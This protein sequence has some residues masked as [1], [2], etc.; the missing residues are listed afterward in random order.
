MVCAFVVVSVSTAW[1]Q[2][3]TPVTSDNVAVDFDGGTVN[4]V[5]RGDNADGVEQNTA[6]GLKYTALSNSEIQYALFNLNGSFVDPDVR[7][8]ENSTTIFYLNRQYAYNVGNNPANFGYDGCFKPKLV[9]NN[10][11]TGVKTPGIKTSYIT[12]QI[13]YDKEFNNTEVNNPRCCRYYRL[14]SDIRNINIYRLKYS[15]ITSSVGTTTNKEQANL[16]IGG[17]TPD[18]NYGLYKKGEQTALETKQGVASATVFSQLDPDGHDY[19]AT[20]RNVAL[21]NGKNEFEVRDAAGAVVKSITV[22]RTSVASDPT[23]LRTWA[24]EVCQDPDKTAAEI[25]ENALT[26]SAKAVT[27]GKGHWEIYPDGGRGG[28]IVSSTSENTKI[29]KL[30]VGVTQYAWVVVNSTTHDGKEEV[31]DTMAIIKVTNNFVKAELSQPFYGTCGESVTIKA[32]DPTQ[33]YG[34]T[35]EMEWVFFSNDYNQEDVPTIQNADSY[36]AIV[37][38]L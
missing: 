21:A 22:T 11:M 15:D 12:D 10:T 20:F 38:D 36:Q 6:I 25:G 30:P 7:Y 26:L 9:P 5:I 13:K 35:V 28:A 37:S 32:I 14:N 29:D 16:S 2:G 33:K 17:L 24:V 8:V 34:S 4:W 18:E 19:I 31:C 27:Y 1:G 3:L 23:G